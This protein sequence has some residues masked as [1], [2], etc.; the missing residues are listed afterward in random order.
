[1]TRL[2]PPV[3]SIY[4]TDVNVNVVFGAG[5]FAAWTTAIVAGNR[6]DLRLGI[7]VAVILMGHTVGWRPAFLV[8]LHPL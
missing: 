8:P 1:M 6:M 5:G 7:L 3:E 2:R 4:E